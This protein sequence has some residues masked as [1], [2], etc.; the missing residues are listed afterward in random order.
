MTQL[1]VQKILTSPL[2]QTGRSGPFLRLVLAEAAGYGMPANVIAALDDIGAML[3][4][5]APLPA[6]Q[7]AHLA[8]PLP[9][10][11]T[12]RRQPSFEQVNDVAALAIKQ[13]AL[14][15]FGGLPADVRVGTAEIVTAMGNTHMDTM[16]PQWRELF[17]WASVD[18]LA[19]IMQQSPEQVRKDKGWPLVRDADVLKP[20]GRLHA[21]YAECANTIRRQAIASR[22]L[23]AHYLSSHRQAQQRVKA[24]GNTQEADRLGQTISE[25]LSMYPELKGTEWDVPVSC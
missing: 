24:A 8:G 14:I 4:F 22:P 7:S 13:R 18:V 6:G 25:I 17:Q 10:W 2:T 12:D 1:D 19:T 3:G 11:R 21:A 9:H 16:P 15:A 23:A 20:D 5:Y